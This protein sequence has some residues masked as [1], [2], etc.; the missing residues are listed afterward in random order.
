MNRRS[1]L[2][3]V[4]VAGAVA[5]GSSERAGAAS[6]SG[7][8][9]GYA[10][11][12]DTTRCVGCRTCEIVCAEANGLPEPDVM[13]DTVLEAVRKTDEKQWTVVNRFE[14]DAGEVFVKRQC[15]HC[16]QPAC[17]SACLTKAMFKTDEGPVIWREQQVHGLP[18]LHGLVPVRHAEVR[19]RQRQPEDP[20]VHACA[21]SGC[22]K[23]E[24]P[25]CVENC[26]AEAL[27]F[28]KRSELLA[29]AR[30]RIYE[31]PET[32]RPPHL[33]RARGR[34]HRL[35]LPLRGAVRADRLPHRPGQRR[36]T[37]SSPGSSSTACRSC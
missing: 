13:D 22:R 36:P 14:T 20:E 15:M 19:V 7:G 35:A 29:E 17:A 12:V 3:T 16:L 24:L 28:G 27:T 18:L 5:M 11:L 32:L 34:R 21:G 1:F 23:G 6:E 33:R 9:E 25:A 30:K 4:G 2:K 37:R 8:I 31:D 26:P 10:I